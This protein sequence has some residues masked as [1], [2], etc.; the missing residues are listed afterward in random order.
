MESIFFWIQVTEPRKKPRHVMRNAQ[1]VAP[2]MLKIVKCRWLI[3]P[4][5]AITGVKVRTIGTN[6]AR[7]TALPPCFSKKAPVRSTCSFLNRRES[8]RLKIDGPARWP[9]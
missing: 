8:G 5:P 3:R 2:M 6:W 1:N 9:M 7:V 4:T